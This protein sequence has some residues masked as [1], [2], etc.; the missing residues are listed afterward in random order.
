MRCDKLSQLRI[1]HEDSHLCLIHANLGLAALPGLA[2]DGPESL[3][4][5]NSGTDRKQGRRSGKM[6]SFP[7]GN[8]C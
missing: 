3:V 4:G 2:L 8:V 1:W 6:R 7:R 5:N